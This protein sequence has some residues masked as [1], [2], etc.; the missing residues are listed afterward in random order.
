LR[1][2][3]NLN[4]PGH[5]RYFDSTIAELIGRGHE[6]LLTFTSPHE[7]AASLDNLAG[8][9]PPPAN[10]GW[11]PKRRDDFAQPARQV[12]AALDYVRYLDP[13]YA[14][15]EFLRTRALARTTSGALF[16]PLTA[17]RQLRRW[18]VNLLMRCLVAAERTIPSSAEIE[19]FIRTARPD[20]LLVSPLLNA[21]SYQTDYVKSAMALGIPTGVCVAS[22]GQPD[23]QG[24]HQGRSR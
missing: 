5:L 15:A 2:L 20:V 13:R 18:Q 21:A 10:L 8:F 14:R 17:R 11:A 19:G 7:Y 16:R 1:V 4:T 22:L 12:R 6:V 24:P 23:Q 3:F 9:D